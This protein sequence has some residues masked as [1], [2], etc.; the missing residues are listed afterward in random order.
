MGACHGGGER[1]SLGMSNS[2]QDS[3]SR[4]SR[5]GVHVTIGGYLVALVL[6]ALVTI[7]V[8][9]E[10]PLVHEDG[11]QVLL[12]RDGLHSALKTGV[13]T[14]EVEDDLFDMLTSP[15]SAPAQPSLAAGPPVMF[16]ATIPSTELTIEKSVSACVQRGKP[17]CRTVAPKCE[18]MGPVCTYKKMCVANSKK[19]IPNGICTQPGK[20]C[21]YAF[22][23]KC[24]ACAKTS[25]TCQRAHRTAKTCVPTCEQTCMKDAVCETKCAQGCLSKYKAFIGKC[26]KEC[27]PCEEGAVKQVC[28]D[29]C[30][31]WKSCA[32]S[33]DKCSKVPFCEKTG[34][35]C[36]F[37]KECL[38]RE[39]QCGPVK[40]C[41]ET[42]HECKNETHCVRRDTKCSHLPTAACSTCRAN[43]AA[44]EGQKRV[45]AKCY[46]DCDIHCK[47]AKPRFAKQCHTSCYHG[48]H[49]SEAA[50]G[51]LC[52]A[53]CPACKLSSNGCHLKCLEKQTKKTC[54]KVCSKHVEAQECKMACTQD[55]MKKH[56]VSVCATWSKRDQCKKTCNKWKFSDKRPC[57]HSCRT[58]GFQ[59]VCSSK[60]TRCSQ[61][62]G[63]KTCDKAGPCLKYQ[64]VQAAQP[65]FPAAPGPVILKN[66]P[67]AKSSA[68][69]SVS[70]Q[71]DKD[72]LPEGAP[73]PVAANSTLGKVMRKATS[74]VF[75]L[76]SRGSPGKATSK[77]I[78]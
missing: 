30:K 42:K 39:K 77:F 28:W 52:G 25:A 7:T 6:L 29:T 4:C 66:P 35:Q 56:C 49:A 47:K 10:S 51:K 68:A 73:S 60:K 46:S 55:T 27:P 34:Q 69:A 54:K 57:S 48:C 40:K 58:H 44:C 74:D 15:D 22:S 32:N 65:F 38:K 16:T 3:P 11:E 62:S 59:Q 31:S 33:A 17:S 43:T 78:N 18:K 45:K 13:E 23:K 9:Q 53:K 64:A 37:K 36:A 72:G 75:R 67:A 76:L 20:Q 71:L 19:C 12:S 14:P 2:P 5:L 50:L 70:N 21:N 1:P 61:W 63:G 8:V 24:I 41:V 26:K